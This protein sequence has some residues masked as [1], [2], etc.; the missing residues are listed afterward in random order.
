M[1]RSHNAAKP[2]AAHPSQPGRGREAAALTSEAA[3]PGRNRAPAGPR[4][5]AG[6][7][8]EAA[9]CH[10][11]RSRGLPLSGYHPP[12]LTGIQPTEGPFRST[13][14][15]RQTP[16]A[17]PRSPPRGGWKESKV[18]VTKHFK[19]RISLVFGEFYIRGVFGCGLKLRGLGTPSTAPAVSLALRGL[20][21]EHR[22]APAPLLVRVR[23]FKPGY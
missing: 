16:P 5:A 1:T 3:L 22:M 15:C 4:A 14:G 11:C 9:A 21:S 8:E 6:L 10:R 12:G 2:H 23:L 18:S 7:L 20:G 19:I 13:S 17:S